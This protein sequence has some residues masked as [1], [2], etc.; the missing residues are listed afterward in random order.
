MI[1]DKCSCKKMQ[2]IIKNIVLLIIEDLQINQIY[3]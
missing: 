1:I 3:L 2:W